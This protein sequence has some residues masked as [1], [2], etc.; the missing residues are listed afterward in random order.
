MSAAPSSPQRSLA[1]RMF[2]EGPA[3]RMSTCE[4]PPLLWSDVSGGGGGVDVIL[5]VPGSEHGLLLRSPSNIRHYI[6]NLQVIDNQR[7]LTQL[8]RTLEC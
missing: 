1:D 5:V 8:S 6:Q 3:T 7:K 4:S 2:L